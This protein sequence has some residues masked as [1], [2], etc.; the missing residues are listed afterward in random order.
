MIQ[1]PCQTQKAEWLSINQTSQQ[2]KEIELINALDCNQKKEN[3]PFGILKHEGTTLPVIRIT[4]KNK[5]I[6]S[7][8]KG[9]EQWWFSFVEKNFN[10]FQKL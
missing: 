7:E 6:E 10:S 3:E 2:N 9:T 5:N 1:S 8:S 4:F